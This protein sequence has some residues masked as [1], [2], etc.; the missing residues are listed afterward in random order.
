MIIVK[1]DPVTVRDA[2]RNEAPA[3]PRA[4]RTGTVCPAGDIGGCLDTIIDDLPW[5]GQFSPIRMARL[6]RRKA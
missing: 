6:W 1:D 3:C 4:A 5:G 2:D